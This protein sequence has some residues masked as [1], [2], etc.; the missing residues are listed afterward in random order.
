METGGFWAVKFFCLSLVQGALFSTTWSFWAMCGFFEPAEV[1]HLASVTPIE[2][3][4]PP[5]SAHQT[6]RK[7]L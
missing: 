3:A 5:H 4:Y 1:R 7:G 2:F 6:C